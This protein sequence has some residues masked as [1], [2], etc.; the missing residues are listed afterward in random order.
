M[1]YKRL[2][3]ALFI[4]HPTNS[5][6]TDPCLVY[7]F[8]FSF[9]FV[10]FIPQKGNPIAFSQVSSFFFSFG[11]FECY[12]HLSC[13]VFL[14]NAVEHI[15][16]S[17]I[18]R[19]L[20]FLSDEFRIQIQLDTGI[21]FYAKKYRRKFVLNDPPWVLALRYYDSLLV[22]TPGYFYIMWKTHQSSSILSC[23]FL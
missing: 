17:K 16:H 4:F 3:I 19:S 15:Y 18:H 2:S 8:A 10:I 22:E 12:V 11:Q 21:Y 1:I 6:V 13:C 14:Y 7:S 23:F 9:P 5:G 20:G